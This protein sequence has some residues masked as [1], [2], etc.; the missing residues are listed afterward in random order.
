M[1]GHATC[2][3]SL[4]YIIKEGR[5]AELLGHIRAILDE[6]AKEADFITAVLHRTPDRPRELMLYELWRGT[7]ETFSAT[8][9]TRS[10]RQAYLAASRPL[11]DSVQVSWDTPIQAWGAIAAGI[12]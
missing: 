6:C 5:E 3:L 4:H 10:Y 11:I 12:A 8:Q 2:A 9:G 1:P 7:R